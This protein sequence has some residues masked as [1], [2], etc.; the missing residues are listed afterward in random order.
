MQAMTILSSMFQKFT[1]ETLEDKYSARYPC[2]ITVLKV[3]TSG[4]KGFHL[5]P[6]ILDRDLVQ[7]MVI[8]TRAPQCTHQWFGFLWRK[9]CK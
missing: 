8:N 2:G 7:S 9:G 1:N 5:C 3:I 6:L 4:D